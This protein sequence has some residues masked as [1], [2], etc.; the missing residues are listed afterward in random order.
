[1]ADDPIHIAQR[2]IIEAGGR[3]VQS[4]GL[5]RLFGQIYAL[6]YMNPEPLSLD[7]ISAQL[8]VSKASISIACRQLESWGALRRVWQKGDRR[9]YYVAENDFRAV[10]NNGLISSLNKKLDSA[11]VQ[12][13]RSLELLERGRGRGDDERVLFLK[14]RLKEA[15]KFRSRINRLLN[16]P[17][18]RR[19]F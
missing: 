5:N 12:L 9:D 7:S 2:E 17:V 13:E 11:R 3:T 8:G 15:E 6:L 19:M 16:N 14:Q 1:M 10:I 18:V 4:F